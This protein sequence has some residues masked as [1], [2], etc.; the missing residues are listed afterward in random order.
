[1][2]VL[3]RLLA[4]IAGAIAFIAAA[5]FFSFLFLVGAAVAFALWS[6]LW[7]K[8]R[9]LRQQ[10]AASRQEPGGHVIEGEYRAE[11]HPEIPGPPPDPP[12]R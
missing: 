12:S 6:W 5:A 9:H 2:S 10:A 11:D 3:A 7:W 4:L 1:M 8:T